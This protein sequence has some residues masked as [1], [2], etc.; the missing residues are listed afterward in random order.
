MRRRSASPAPRPLDEL[1]HDPT[2]KDP[3]QHE[4]SHRDEKRHADR[5]AGQSGHGL[6]SMTGRRLESDGEERLKSGKAV[7]A[8]LLLAGVV[9]AAAIVFF[10][11]VLTRACG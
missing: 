3:R 10:W 7:A 5:Q 9:G 1:G 2:Q 4:Q 6:P 8:A 11:V